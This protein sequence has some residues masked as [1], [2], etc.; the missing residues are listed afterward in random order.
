MNEKFTVQ[1]CVE[2]NQAWDKAEDFVC[3][4]L[5]ALCTDSGI[6]RL[7]ERVRRVDFG[8]DPMT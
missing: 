4:K 3:K 6:S 2:Q 1:R 5:L 8:S 7:E